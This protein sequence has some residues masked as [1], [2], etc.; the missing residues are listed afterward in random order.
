VPDKKESYLP[1]YR[2]AGSFT[3]SVYKLWHY[4]DIF[5]LFGKEFILF[6]G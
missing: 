3:T 2:Q 6:P 1:A 4:P 5:P